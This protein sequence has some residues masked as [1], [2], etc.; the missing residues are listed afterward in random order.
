MKNW[1]KR[2]LT[3]I[4]VGHWTRLAGLLLGA[5]VLLAFLAPNAGATTQTATAPCLERGN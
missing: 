2:L 5:G 4:K 1:M 3:T